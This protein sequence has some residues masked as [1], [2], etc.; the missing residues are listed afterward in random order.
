[1]DFAQQ[2]RNPIRHLVGI[3]GVV[4][5]HVLVIYALVTVP[6]KAALGLGLALV[7]NQHMRFSNPIRAA[8]MMPWIVPTHSV[9]CESGPS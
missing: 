3:G 8:V 6:F 4:L 9:W 7:L 1:M 2:Q 5:L